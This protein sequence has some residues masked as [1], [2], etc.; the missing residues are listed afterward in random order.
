MTKGR[1]A[2]F[3][4]TAFVGLGVLPN[5]WGSGARGQATVAVNIRPLSEAAAKIGSTIRAM[6]RMGFLLLHWRTQFAFAT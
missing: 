3:G 2:G 5:H 1:P 6:L 4:G